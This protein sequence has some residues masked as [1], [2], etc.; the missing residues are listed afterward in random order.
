MQYFVWI[1][2]C[3]SILL[4]VS[5]CISAL[6]R[7]IVL[8]KHLGYIYGRFC[9]SNIDR[10]GCCNIL[11]YYFGMQSFYIIHVYMGCTCQLEVVIY[12]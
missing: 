11:W 3:I 1:F 7:I 4:Y 6:L 8:P 10:E 9:G 12:L 5:F 2:L